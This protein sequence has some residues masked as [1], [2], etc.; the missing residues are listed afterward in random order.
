MTSF[1]PHEKKERMERNKYGKGEQERDR[2]KETEP[3]DI[4]RPDH[5]D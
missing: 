1:G 3:R 4:P 5:E 2:E